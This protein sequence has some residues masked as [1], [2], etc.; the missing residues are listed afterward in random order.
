VGNKMKRDFLK[1][2]N[3]ENDVIDKIM[4]QYGADV[5]LLKASNLSQVKEIQA[6]ENDIKQ[7]DEQLEKL[8]NSTANIDDLK[9]QIE[10]LQNEN[11]TNNEK[12]QNELKQ[13]KINNAVEKALTSANARNKKVIIPLLSEFLSKANLDEQ[14]MVIGLSE[15]IQ[16]LVESDDTKFLFGTSQSTLKGVAPAQ[17]SDT[18]TG[19]IDQAAFDANKNN[20]DWIN[21][22]W[23]TISVALKEGTIKG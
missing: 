22:N 5:E 21:K 2:L 18:Q 20:P 13:I 10:T 11:K 14:G 1:S 17:K 8:K 6:L 3:I 23:D 16:K 12:Y 4:A 7:R 9:A 19:F 15:Q